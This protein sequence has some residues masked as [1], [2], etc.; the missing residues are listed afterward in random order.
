MKKLVLQLAMLFF[1]VSLLITGCATPTA[2]KAEDKTRGVEVITVVEESFDEV[3]R[4]IG[5]ITSE[6]MVPVQFSQTAMVE[7]ILVKP[8]DQVEMGD[9]I[10]ISTIPQESIEIPLLSPIDGYVVRI[11]KNKNE[12]G[13]VEEVFAIVGGE[14]QIATFGMIQDD[15]ARVDESSVFRVEVTAGSNILRGELLGIDRIPDMASRT[16]QAKVEIFS[17]NQFLIGELC[18]VNIYL[19]TIT[20]VWLPIVY[21]QNDG[22]DYVYIVNDNNRIER[23]NLVMHEL[24]DAYVRV[25]GL[26]AGERVVVVGNAFVREGQEVTYKEATHE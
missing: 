10:A 26:E 20:G 16:Y 5:N 2:P 6:Q 9:E 4:Y 7:T 11:N 3:L 21:V 25:E 8:G 22:Q 13:Q 23:R 15:V 17:L 14:S 19:D 18:E 12:W 24:N 1:V